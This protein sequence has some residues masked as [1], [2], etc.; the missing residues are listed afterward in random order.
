ML[1]GSFRI[2]HLEISQR[3]KDDLGNNQSCVF[4]IVGGNDVPRRTVSACPMKSNPRTPSCTASSIFFH[5][6]RSSEFPSFYP[7]LQC[8][9]EI[10]FVAH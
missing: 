2:G 10:S 1:F 7:V 3:I 8:V 9:R 5:E 6:C 4:L